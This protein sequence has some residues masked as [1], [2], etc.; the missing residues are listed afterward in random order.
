[1]KAQVK[2]LK[3]E[4]IRTRNRIRLAGEHKTDCFVER[5]KLNHLIDTLSFMNCIYNDKT[6]QFAICENCGDRYILKR[7]DQKHHNNTCKQA[8]FRKNKACVV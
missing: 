7:V 2:F 6:L 3:N 1:M 8:L 5:Q 4:I